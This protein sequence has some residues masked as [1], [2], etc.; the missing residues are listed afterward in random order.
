[1]VV[2]AIAPANLEKVT[3]T[4]AYT[5]TPGTATLVVVGTI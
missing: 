4:G 2:G 5:V 3:V 1:V